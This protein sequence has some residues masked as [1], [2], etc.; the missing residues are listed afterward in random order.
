M[1][2]LYKITKNGKVSFVYGT[3]HIQ[4][5]EV[6]TISEETKQAFEQSSCVVVEMTD[7]EQAKVDNYLPEILEKWKTHF[8]IDKHFTDYLSETQATQIMKLFDDELAQAHSYGLALTNLLESSPILL[9]QKI[10]VKQLI[11]LGLLGSDSLDK[12]FERQAKRIGK[13]TAMLDSAEDVAQRFAGLSF[14]CQEQLEYAK[15]VLDKQLSSTEEEIKKMILKIVTTYLAGNPKELI[16]LNDS[17]EPDPICKSYTKSLVF[18]RDP[19]FIQAMLTHLEAGNAFI[20]MGALHIPGVI[21]LLEKECDCVI[22][23]I[24]EGNRLYKINTL[25]NT[26]KPLR[27]AN[28]LSEF[29]FSVRCE[30]SMFSCLFASEIDFSLKHKQDLPI[31]LELIREGKIDRNKKIKIVISDTYNDEELLILSDI[32]QEPN[33]PKIIDINL[34]NNVSDAN[35][36]FISAIFRSKCAIEELNI[37]FGHNNILSERSLEYLTEA[38]NTKMFTGKLD[39]TMGNNNFISSNQHKTVI[40]L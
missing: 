21:S 6:C 30:K 8:Q 7:E 31:F 13:P 39:M 35:I 17:S 29:E 12:Q 23:P 25:E 27:K 16:K 3:C 38:L 34:M 14:T 2:N 11:N 4:N 24:P 5:D 15:C 26:N 32:L 1:P 37:N 40:S 36:A 18:Q 10:N 19:V 28:L 20:A 22:E 9:C 33:A